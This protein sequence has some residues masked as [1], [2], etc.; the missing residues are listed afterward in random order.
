MTK[1][2][3]VVINEE[4]CNGCGACVPD[5]AEG[6]LQIVNGKAKLVADKYCDGLGACLGVCPEDAIEI[7]EREAENF[8]EAAVEQHLSELKTQKAKE[9][10]EREKE[11]PCACPSTT[12]MEFNEKKSA[13]AS[14]EGAPESALSQW[15][16]QISLVPAGAPYFE[17][18]DLLIAADC[19][20]FSYGPFHQELL[21]GRAVLIGCPK[22]DDPN[23]YIEK[24]AQI[25]KESNIKTITIAHMEVPCCFGIIHIV[26]KALEGAGKDI[27]V[28]EVTITIGGERKE[29]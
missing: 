27:P 1:R 21:A 2:E 5:C 15:P 26:K 13:A 7:I 14:K 10:A 6:A 18:A 17:D 24:I 20:P 25:L 16:I 23:F 8:N 11:R 9:R 22:L 28:D 19:V 4:K 3:V 29:K 12:A